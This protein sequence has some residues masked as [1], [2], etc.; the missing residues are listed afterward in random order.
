MAAL[1]KMLATVDLGSGAA[2]KY[3][4]MSNPLLY[5]SIGPIVGISLAPETDTQVVHRVEDLVLYGILETFVVRTGTTSANRK[6]A[7]ILCAAN[8][9]TTAEAELIG[10][11]IPQG[12]ITAISADLKAQNYLP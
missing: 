1:K 3:Y 4:F 9:A 7:R 12:T 8:K 2:A 11:A 5:S 6:S 10:K